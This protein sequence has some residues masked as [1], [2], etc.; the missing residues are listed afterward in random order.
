MF[1]LFEKTDSQI[2][3]DVKS[4]LKWDPSVADSQITV[5]AS[6]GIVTLRGSVPHYFEKRTAEKAAQRVGG[7]RAVADEIGVELFTTHK[8]TDQEIA[9]AAL[10]A[11]KWNYQVPDDIKVSVD[12]G[13]I[14]LR[15]E[16]DW[17]FQKAAASNA[18]NHMIGVC[19]VSNEIIIKEKVQPSDVK[20]RIE[21]ALKRSAEREGRKIN[22]AVKGSCV[23]LSGNVH[24]YSEIG[25]AALAAWN[26]PG[27]SQ[28]ENNLKLTH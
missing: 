19:G 8:K 4:E 10:N 25:D 27:V 1:N 23:T 26:A 5:T 6:D 9:E 15:G 13:W 18:V 2:Q 16:T 7:V 14:T 3:K 22:V 28:V 24:S 21:E 20:T 17:A 11:L 12:N